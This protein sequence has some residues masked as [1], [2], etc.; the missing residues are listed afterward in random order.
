MKYFTKEC[1]KC[2][3]FEDGGDCFACRSPKHKWTEEETKKWQEE[4]RGKEF[5]VRDSLPP[6]NPKRHCDFQPKR[7]CLFCNKQ[8]VIYV[9]SGFFCEACHKYQ[10]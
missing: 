5:N 10:E 9:G 6:F 8:E 3:W 2:L 1:P 7:H 4:G